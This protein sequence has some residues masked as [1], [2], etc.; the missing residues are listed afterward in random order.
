M[1]TADEERNA[2]EDLLPWRAAGTLSRSEAQRVDAALQADPELARRYA[3]IREEVAQTVQLNQALGT[4]SPRA[5]ENL[6]AKIDAE[7]GS[8]LVTSATL[9]DRLGEFFAALSPRTLTLGASAAALVLALQAGVIGNLV[10][11]D[12]QSG[13]YQTAS[14]TSQ[15][16]SAG[17]YVLVRFAPQANADAITHF[18]QAHKFLI[19]SGPSAG[20]LY[21]VRVAET[22][23]TA[24][25]LQ[26]LADSLQHDKIV[27]LAV[28]SE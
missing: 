15:P 22:K 4:P 13:G 6:F 11:K 9:F 28:P 16:L 10:L 7:P 20:G 17:S 26:Q 12:K 21:V 18:L 14:E 27:G 2:I 3:L 25:D 19:T 1:N 24:P 5:L 8:R 23:M